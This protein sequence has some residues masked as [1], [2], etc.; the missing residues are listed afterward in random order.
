MKKRRSLLLSLLALVIITGCSATIENQN[1]LGKPFPEVV[2]Q[3][4]NQ[5]SVSLPLDMQGETTLFLIGYVQNTQFDIDRWLIGLDMTKTQVPFYELPTI[6]GMFP[7][8]FQ[9]TIDNGMRKGIPKPLWGGVVTI[10]QDAD[11][12][13]RLTGTQN[14]NNARVMLIDP[15]GKIVFFYDQGFSVDALNDLRAILAGND[16][17]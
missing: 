13:Q 9:T 10:Y 16:R 15:K 1:P 4:L 12:I 17:G 5:Q 11:K 8:M 2:G 6:S 7:R 14:P 3:N